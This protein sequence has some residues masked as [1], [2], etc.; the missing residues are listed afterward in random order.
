MVETGRQTQGLVTA[1]FSSLLAQS[2]LPSA[3][4]LKP[5]SDQISHNQTDEN[6]ES[7]IGKRHKCRPLLSSLQIAV[8]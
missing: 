8:H 3:R 1:H 4:L 5:I 6:R 2:S 7:G